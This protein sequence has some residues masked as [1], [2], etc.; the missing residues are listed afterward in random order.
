MKKFQINS[1][2]IQNILNNYI[3][4]FIFISFVLTMVISIFSPRFSYNFWNNLVLCFS[5]N[6]IISV[7]VLGIAMNTYNT[8]NV[9]KKNY[10]ITL[11]YYQKNISYDDLIKYSM[12]TTNLIIAIFVVLMISCSIFISGKNYGL[13]Y[14]FNIPVYVYIILI[15][16]KLIVVSNLLNILFYNIFLYF[17]KWY[18]IPS[19]V[20]LLLVNS[21]IY[22]TYPN[23]LVEISYTLFYIS[24]LLFIIA[25]IKFAIR[26]KKSENSIFNNW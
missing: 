13:T 3:S 7:L 1:Q 16:L 19:V 21:Y 25:L 17:N 12:K 9:F 8:L 11:R 15:I 23:F 5:D 26:R 6:V 2:I 14:I 4:R 24:I 18:S 20:I 22:S 10:F